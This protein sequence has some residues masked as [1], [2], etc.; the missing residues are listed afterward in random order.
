[1]PIFG[2]LKYPV[3]KISLKNEFVPPFC[4]IDINYLALLLTLQKTRIWQ[5][6]SSRSLPPPPI[7]P[8]GRRPCGDCFAPPM[9]RRGWARIVEKKSLSSRE[10]IPELECKFPRMFLVLV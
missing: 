1:M 10:R 9:K 4:T 3:L 5:H 8:V 7:F 2:Y 6:R